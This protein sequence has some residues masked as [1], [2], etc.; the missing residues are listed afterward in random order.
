V[1]DISF[2]QYD[3]ADFPTIEQSIA[4]AETNPFLFNN[5]SDKLVALLEGENVVVHEPYNVLQSFIWML[6]PFLVEY[7]MPEDE[8][9][10]PEKT[11][12]KL[13]DS[14]DF[15][16]VCMLVNNCVSC[17]DYKFKKY[18]VLPATE[19]YHIETFLEKA[20]GSLRVYNPDSSTVFK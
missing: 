1:A 11:A 14:H 15:W 10:M 13:Y 12:K 20:R 9:Y 2:A 16:Y 6:E 5:Y 19:L 18:K 4:H 3:S 17:M 7:D 8:Y